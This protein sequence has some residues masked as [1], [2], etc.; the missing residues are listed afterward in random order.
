MWRQADYYKMAQWTQELIQWAD[1]IC[2]KYVL[3]HRPES[4]WEV[5]RR[6]ERLC[7]FALPSSTFV[8]RCSRKL[9]QCSSTSPHRN[10]NVDCSMRISTVW[11]VHWNTIVHWKIWHCGRWHSSSECSLQCD[12]W[13]GGLG[14]WHQPPPASPAL[15]HNNDHPTFSHSISHNLVHDCSKRVQHALSSYLPHLIY[16]TLCYIKPAC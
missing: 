3:A 4:K 12:C 13:P 1:S 14:S 11:L 10:S 9:P 15:L 6:E 16:T 8:G 5:E 2:A 7:H